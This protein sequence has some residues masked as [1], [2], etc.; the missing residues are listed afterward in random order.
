MKSLWKLARVLCD[1]ICVEVEVIFRSRIE[2]EESTE[3]WHVG[4]VAAEFETMVATIP[5][6]VVMELMLLLDR[7]LRHVAI[8]TDEKTV[9]ESKQVQVCR[10]VNAVVESLVLVG[11][12]VDCTRTNRRR[13]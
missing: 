12:L 3:R 8:A 11:E 7:L 13:Q 9:G 10:G 2:S 6:D 5:R 4:K 1:L